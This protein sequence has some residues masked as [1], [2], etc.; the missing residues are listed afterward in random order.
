M[1]CERV[2]L[3]ICDSN[4]YVTV[5]AARYVI[6]CA[7]R[8]VTV[9]AAWYVIVCAARYVIVCAAWYTSKYVT[10]CVQHG[11]HTGPE[12]CSSLSFTIKYS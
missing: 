1:K 9:C 7:A 8:Y 3:V 11:I 5:C 2:N 12:N 4:G 10:V 6:V